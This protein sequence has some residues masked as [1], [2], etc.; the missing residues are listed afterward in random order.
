MG[1][2]LAFANFV[3]NFFACPSASNDQQF[4]GV[5]SKAEKAMVRKPPMFLDQIPRSC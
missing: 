5:R 4:R 1:A 3:L 2:Q